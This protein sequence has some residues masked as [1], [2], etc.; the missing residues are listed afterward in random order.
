METGRGPGDTEMDRSSTY[1]FTLPVVAGVPVDPEGLI[2]L[3]QNMV[4]EHNKRAS[5]W[6]K[7][8]EQRLRNAGLETSTLR[9]RLRLR[10]RGRL[11]RNNAFTK[12]VDFRGA[13]DIDL[14]YATRCDVYLEVRA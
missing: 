11:G 1:R 4:R 13:R 14:M 8:D 2:P 3:Y 12:L 9:D 7:V 10:V 6:S 5:A